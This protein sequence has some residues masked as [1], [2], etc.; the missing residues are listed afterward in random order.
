MVRY[1]VRICQYP[2]PNLMVPLWIY[3][4]FHLQECL[5]TALEISTLINMSNGVAEGDLEKRD[6]WGER[7]SK[8]NI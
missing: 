7:A 1:P 4:S 3:T 8:K 2:L 6:Q 5:L